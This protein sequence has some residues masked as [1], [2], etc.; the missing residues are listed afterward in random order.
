MLWLEK[1][2]KA[3]CSA[4]TILEFPQNQW[5]LI[6]IKPPEGGL[7]RKSFVMCEQIKSMSR[8]RLERSPGEVRRETMMKVQE[9]VQVILDS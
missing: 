3:F 6:T 7:R 5:N 4:S 9:I 1:S 8:D 2:L